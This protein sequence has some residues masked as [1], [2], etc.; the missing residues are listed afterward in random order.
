MQ[1]SQGALVMRQGY[2]LL[3]QPKEASPEHVVEPDDVIEQQTKVR[4]HPNLLWFPTEPLFLRSWSSIYWLDW[5]APLLLVVVQVRISWVRGLSWLL[6]IKIMLSSSG[7][8]CFQLNSSII[9]I[10]ESTF[11]DFFTWELDAIL[12]VTLSDY[13]L[14]CMCCK[15]FILMQRIMVHE[16]ILSFFEKEN[17][18]SYLYPWPSWGG[19]F[20]RYW[21]WYMNC[22]FLVGPF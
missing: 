13:I 15:T 18:M 1:W 10:I 11:H 19:K 21:D 2:N 7:K 16:K 22:E 3:G 17:V 9:L 14:C 4:D 20:K 12:N 8:D 5:I 6:K